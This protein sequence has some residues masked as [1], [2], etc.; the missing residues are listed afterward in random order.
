MMN[1]S[2]MYFYGF[3]NTFCINNVRPNNNREDYLPLILLHLVKGVEFRGIAVN[4]KF[5]CGKALI[6]AKK[7]AVKINF[8]YLLMH[9]I[10]ATT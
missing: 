3:R 9:V 6:Y 7:L 8:F 4:T 10:R 2:S 5:L 1:Y